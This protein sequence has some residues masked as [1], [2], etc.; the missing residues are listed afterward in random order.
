[1][2][3]STFIDKNHEEEVLIYAH[4]RNNIVLEIERLTSNNKNIIGINNRETIIL[5]LNIVNC[6]ISENNKVYALINDK[7]Y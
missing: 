2:K 1:M 6:F 4:E 5:D 7:R 3:C